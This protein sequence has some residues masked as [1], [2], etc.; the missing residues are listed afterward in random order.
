M[1]CIQHAGGKEK[2]L[3]DVTEFSISLLKFQTFIPN[4]NPEFQTFIYLW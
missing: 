4:K 2:Q 1:W 3:H